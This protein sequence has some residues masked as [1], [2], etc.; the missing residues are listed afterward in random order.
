[1]QGS[2]LTPA[3]LPEASWNRFGQVIFQLYLPDGQVSKYSVLT[4]INK[5]ISKHI[6]DLF[7]SQ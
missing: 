6:L 2:K 7:L 3:R 5:I 4:N 1:M